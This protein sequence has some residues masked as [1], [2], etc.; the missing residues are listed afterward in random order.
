MLKK[1]LIV[2][3]GFF[4]QNS[5][6]SF[7]AT[8]L[9][10]EF[11]LQGHEVT[12]LTPRVTVHDDFEK[13]HNLKIIDLG[14]LKWKSPE[15]GNSKIGHILSRILFRLLQLSI[16]Y[17]DIELFFK[18]RKGLKHLSGFDLL[19]SIAV[20]YPIHWGVAAVWD[21][22]VKPAKTW[23]ADCGDPFMGEQTDSFRKWFYFKYVEKWFMHKADYVS[24]PIESAKNAYYSDFHQ[25]IRIIPQ[26]FKFDHIPDSVEPFSSGIPH[27]AYA[28]G[29][30]PG[31]RDPRPLLNFLSTLTQDFRFYIYTNN[32]DLVDPYL[33][34]LNPKLI[35]HG[36]LPREQLLSEISKM[37]FL[38]NFD[39]NTKAQLPSKLIDYAIVNRPV[40]NIT[41]E[42]DLK[43]IKEFLNFDYSKRMQLGNVSQYNIK[44][45][46]SRFLE[47]C[48]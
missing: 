36:Y 17:P 14:T 7:R 31:K 22:K 8:E 34:N 48:H 26:G 39:N 15:F 19:I 13:Q 42:L 44:N 18:V 11:A 21:K 25:K 27:F 29:F 38:I 12:V 37:H 32:G 20:P 33:S 40:L 23:V 35:V 45:V 9:A 46:A 28:G 16:E 47:L 41:R 4:P 6:R 30:I 10:K 1:I 24:I 3:K 43:T 5:P 2:C